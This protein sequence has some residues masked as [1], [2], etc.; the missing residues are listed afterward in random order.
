MIDLSI[1]VEIR[2][3]GLVCFTPGVQWLLPPIVAGQVKTE[4]AQR[5]AADL[6][7]AQVAA[8][9]LVNIRQAAMPDETCLLLDYGVQ[10]ALTDHYEAAYAN[11]A[12]LVQLGVVFAKAFSDLPLFQDQVESRV[13]RQIVEAIRTQLPA[14]IIAGMSNIW[15]RAREV[16]LSIS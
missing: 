16:R 6:Q 3:K 14:D 15:L 11:T 1:S 2:L 13:R 4:M 7:A 12:G 10:V 5:L 9:G 8:Q